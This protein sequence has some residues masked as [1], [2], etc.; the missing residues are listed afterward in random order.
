MLSSGTVKAQWNAAAA[1]ARVFG[2][3]GGIMAA[4]PQ[5]AAE[6]PRLAAAAAAVLQGSANSKART[7]AAAALAAAAALPAELMPRSALKAALQRV[8]EAQ[9][10]GSSRVGSNGG[11]GSGSS[12]SSGAIGST[13]DAANQARQPGISG[14]EY[15]S[16]SAPLGTVAAAEGPNSG[17]A[18]LPT[19][20]ELRYRASLG[21]QLQVARAALEAALDIPASASHARAGCL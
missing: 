4:A 21:V 13:V 12:S 6:L 3:A 10:Q 20:A 11:G 15:S 2:A 5:A 1:A 18:D 7:Q 8:C 17:G 9:G 16:S 19:V 14:S